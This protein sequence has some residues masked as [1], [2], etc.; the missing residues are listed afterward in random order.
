MEY[1]SVGIHYQQNLL[2]FFPHLDSETSVNLSL[3]ITHLRQDLI[4]IEVIQLL[5]AKS[6]FDNLLAICCNHFKDTIN[7]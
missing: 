6:G 5:A 2:V 4:E 3:S 7:V 1:K